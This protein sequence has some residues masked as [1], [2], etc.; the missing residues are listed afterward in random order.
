MNLPEGAIT[1][2]KLLPF[3][4]DIK[5]IS[6]LNGCLTANVMMRIK[7]VKWYLFIKSL[8]FFFS[9]NSGDAACEKLILLYSLVFHLLID[10]K[11]VNKSGCMAKKKKTTTMQ[12]CITL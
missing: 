6:A 4:N 10:F 8:L 7:H 12:T 9:T 2:I 5:N 3:G 1:K 11:V